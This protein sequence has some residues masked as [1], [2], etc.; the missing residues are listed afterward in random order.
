[1]KSKLSTT[2]IASSVLAIASASVQAVSI[3]GVTYA[4]D[5]VSTSSTF[6]KFDTHGHGGVDGDE[7]NDGSGGDRYN[8]DYM[9]VNVES[10]GNYSFGVQGGN[11]LLDS[12]LE[13]NINTNP[14]Y[15]GDIAINVLQSGETYQD[16]SF[17]TGASSGWDYAIRILSYSTPSS[18]GTGTF[19]YS[20]LATDNDSG[21][22][23]VNIYTR[24]EDGSD[25]HVSDTFRLN[26]GTSVH[27][28][29]GDYTSDSNGLG[30]ILSGSFDL[31]LLS[32]F[33]EAT[34]GSIITYL[35]M[36]CAN[37]EIVVAA[38]NIPP[39]PVPAAF[40]LF[41]SALIGFIGMSRRTKV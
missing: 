28:G 33:D 40:W 6:N 24:D 1:M 4:Y 21:W 32:M 12:H 30:N 37:D 11:I 31:G 38:E 26:N 7:L 19:D 5:A 15:L 8:L 2:L 34:G 13:N 35:T 29:V 20:V 23:A 36:S 3:G 27:T 9:G 17:N 39:V 10:G 25:G 18:G 16:P 22:E 41:G 14:L